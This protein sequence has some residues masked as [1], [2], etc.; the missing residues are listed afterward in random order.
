MQFADLRSTNKDLLE[1]GP[2]VGSLQKQLWR[3]LCGGM[4]PS[5]RAANANN[6]LTKFYKGIAVCSI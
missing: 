2:E 3:E 4:C 5:R 6:K 1:L